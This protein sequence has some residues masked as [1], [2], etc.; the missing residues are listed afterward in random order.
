MISQILKKRLETEIKSLERER[1]LAAARMQEAAS[2][3]DL[4]ENEPYHIAKELVTQLSEELNKK[5][6]LLDQPVGEPLGNT[7]V[8]GRLLKINHVGLQNARSEVVEPVNA[9]ILLLFA[10]DG[11]A[12]V[13]GVLSRRC[14]LG[15]A[16]L[17]GREGRYVVNAGGSQHVYDVQIYKG[18]PNVYLEMFPTDIKE[19]IRSLLMTEDDDLW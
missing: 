2:F 5:I 9:E 1:D 17:N 8:P 13:Q 4:R 11:D 19:R 6:P 15:R 16:I 14:A 10:E 7:L 12:V 3:G 18:D